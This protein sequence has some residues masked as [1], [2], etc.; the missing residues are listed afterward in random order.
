[1]T[2]PAQKI[3]ITVPT[4]QIEAFLEMLR[5]IE[6]VKVESLEDIIRRYVRSAPKPP[7]LSEEEISDILM[8][9]RYAQSPKS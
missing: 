2:V 8:E 4:S 1:M 3:V 5:K 6:F 7:K 9:V